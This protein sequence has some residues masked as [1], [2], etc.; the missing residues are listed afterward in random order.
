M[1]TLKVSILSQV[2]LFLWFY[3]CRLKAKKT[4]KCS[5]RDDDDDF[6]DFCTF[7]RKGTLLCYGLSADSAAPAFGAD[8]AVGDGNN[9]PRLFN[10]GFLKPLFLIAQ[11]LWR[12]NVF[13]SF[14]CR[15][16][17]DS[18]WTYRTGKT[19]RRV[20]RS[21]PDHFWLWIDLKI[22]RGKWRFLLLNYSFK[23]NPS[24]HLTD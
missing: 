17:L 10:P 21:K 15:Y 16:K 13:N 24:N 9:W 5:H 11:A 14:F 23:K 12:K 18:V 20:L 7:W 3:L 22:F 2:S 6:V 8:W 1:W 19:S 4:K